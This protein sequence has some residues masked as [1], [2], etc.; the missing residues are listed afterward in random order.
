MKSIIQDSKVC[1]LCG[2]MGNL[3]KHHVW[4][5]TANRRL[6]D[7]DGLWVWLCRSCHRQVH[8][9]GW[10]DRELMAVGEKAWLKHYGKGIPEFIERY[11]KNVL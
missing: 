6:A 4:H 10:H 9:F 1:F 5:G 3:E 2:Y 7:V 8:D 11:G